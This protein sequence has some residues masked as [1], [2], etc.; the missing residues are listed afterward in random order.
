[1]TADPARK[2][3]RM[4]AAG[5]IG[6]VLEWYDFSIYGYF[7]AAIGRSFFP[8]DEPTT[9]VLAAFGVFAAGYLMRPL[10]GILVGHI[11]DRYGRP[12]ALTFSIVAMAVPTFLVGILPGY[13]TLGVAAPILLTAL[14]MLQGL[15]IGGECTTA[16]IFL[17]ER[18]S[19]ERRG[20]ASA[21]ASSSITVGI[22]LGSATGAAFSAVLSPEALVEWG[23]RVPFILGVV[24]GLA[25]FALRRRADAD[26]AAVA[27]AVVAPI[28]SP[29]AE[30]LR[31]HPAL[32]AKLA[33]LAAFNAVG[34]F[35]VFLYVASWLQLADGVAP[36]RALG[37][38]TLALLVLIPVELGAGWLS[39]RI[40]RK[41]PMLTAIGL[42]FV[43]A[44]P[45]FSLMHHDN[46]TMVLSAELA[47]VV[48]VGIPL[49]IQA[50]LMVEATPAHVRC[51]AVALG[52]NTAFG[53][54]GGLTPLAA[55]WLVQRVGNDLSPAFLIMGAAAISFTA[56]LLFRDS[57]PAVTRVTQS[58]T[59][60]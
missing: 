46:A 23:W 33:G 6:N 59:Q 8:S 48:L 10:G 44:Y 15:S 14:R 36:A 34:F 54:I 53:I 19:P 9:Q 5:T 32:L 58:G 37:V 12:T 47:L 7:A 40:G 20:F 38:T 2:R 50:A 51:T 52:N 35:L 39:D 24:V 56:L 18:A 43:F 3:R 21:L 60:R 41:G 13:Q 42:C 55:T 17:A 29:L 22:L 26:S 31:E 1:M 28:R 57:S 45:L 27:P 11:G 4:L 30:T 16:F 25:G 49:G